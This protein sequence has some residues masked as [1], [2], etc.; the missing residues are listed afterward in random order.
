MPRVWRV[1]HSLFAGHNRDRQAVPYRVPVVALVADEQ[2]R[3]VLSSISDWELFPIHF[4][5]SR[6]EACSAAKRLI[7]PVVLLDRDWPGAEWKTDVQSFAAPPHQACVILL[8][9]VSDVYLW[10]ELVRRGGYDVL[11]KPLQL[12]P[13]QAARMFKLAMAYGLA[14]PS[15]VPASLYPRRP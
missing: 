1:F 9:G 4:A 5:E 15:R 13:N 6:E 8:S 2:D 7:A 11:L 3:R 14:H 12:G 10:Q